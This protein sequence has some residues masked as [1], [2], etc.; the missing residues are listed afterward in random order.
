MAQFTEM[1]YPSAGFHPRVFE[2]MEQLDAMILNGDYWFDTSKREA[3]TE[4]LARW[5]RVHMGNLKSFEAMKAAGEL[6]GAGEL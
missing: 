1:R 2:A 4:L 6:D 5:A 3:M